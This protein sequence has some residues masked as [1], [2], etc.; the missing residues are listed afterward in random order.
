MC[1]YGWESEYS[2]VQT[3]PNPNTLKCNKSG[4]IYESGKIFSSVNVVRVS[5]NRGSTVYCASRMEVELSLRPGG[6]G[7]RQIM[8]ESRYVIPNCRQKKNLA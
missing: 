8:L 2:I 6:G 4:N 5:L 7:G 1:V 3:P